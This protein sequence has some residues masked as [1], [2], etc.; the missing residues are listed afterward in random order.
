MS[1]KISRLFK[2]MKEIEPA[3]GLEGAIL[4]RIEAGKNFKIKRKRI[5]SVF[6]L[7]LSGVASVYAGLT[8]GN[9]I[10]QSEFWKLMSL[11]FSDLGVI[12][13]NWEN[14]VYSLLETF[15]AIYAAIIIAPVFA[16]LLSISSYLNNHNH[17]RH[18]NTI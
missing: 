7:A 2:K 12:S 16:L 17:N 8:F 4:A 13:T 14:Y 1:E 5:I 9:E 18:Y 3:A 15:P 6:G 11:A 10:L